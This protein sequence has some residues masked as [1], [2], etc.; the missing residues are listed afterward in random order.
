MLP[1]N[2]AQHQAH[3]V[4]RHHQESNHFYP[5]KWHM[6]SYKRDKTTLKH[7]LDLTLTAQQQPHPRQ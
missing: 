2:T 7:A 6:D 1:I 5:F 4:V 3:E